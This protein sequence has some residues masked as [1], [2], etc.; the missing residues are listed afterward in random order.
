M[1][2]QHQVAVEH[3]TFQGVDIRYCTFNAQTSMLDQCAAGVGGA[4]KC[5]CLVMFH[6][7]L[8]HHPQYERPIRDGHDT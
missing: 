7:R 1:Y 2:R 6:L 8:I 5:I 4:A 3:N